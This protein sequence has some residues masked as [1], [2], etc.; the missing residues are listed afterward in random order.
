MEGGDA[1]LNDFNPVYFHIT[2]VFQPMSGG[3]TD[4]SALITDPA[5]A[6]EGV[7]GGEPILIRYVN[8]AYARQR[9]TFDGLSDGSLDFDVI[10]SDGRAFD[11]VAPNFA[12][13]FALTGPYETTTAERYDFLVT[14]KQLGTSTVS[15]ESLDWITGE[16]LGIVR[17]TITVV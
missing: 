7:L 8:A 11:N 9:I 12:Q 14:P 13:P 1:G 16:C 10:A 4:P 6:T 15:I 3:S 17:T 5:I 2:G